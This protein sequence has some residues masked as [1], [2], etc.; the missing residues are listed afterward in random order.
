MVLKS[1]LHVMELSDLLQWIKMAR[2]TGTCEFRR[3]EAV[4][5]VYFRDGVIVACAA[6]EPFLLLGQFLLAYGRATERAIDEAMRVQ[7][8]TGENLGAILVQSGAITR[9]HLRRAI[10]AKAEETVFGLFDWPDATFEF[11]QDVAP[12]PDTMAIE[13][14]IQSALLDGARRMDEL[15]RIRET[16]KSQ[17]VV[18]SRTDSEPD[19]QMIAS[20]MGARL[21]DAIDGKR[22]LAEVLLHSRAS[23]EF[24][25]C[26][27]LLRLLEREVVAIT[28]VRE[29]SLS[30]QP[31]AVRADRIRQLVAHGE[32]AAALDLVDAGSLRVKPDD[33]L[34]LLIAKAEAGHIAQIYRSELP[35]HSYPVACGDVNTLRDQHLPA[36]QLFLLD[37]IDGSWDVRSIA[38]IAPMRKVDALRSLRSLLKNGHIRLSEAPAESAEVRRD[39]SLSVEATAVPAEGAIDDAIAGLDQAVCGAKAHPNAPDPARQDPSL[40]TRSDEPEADL[41]I[42]SGDLAIDETFLKRSRRSSS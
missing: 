33:H 22:T 12:G 24:L 20:P 28:G 15:K 29:T 9:E 25:A 32:Y 35:P 39:D 2:K 23:S 7:E 6:N 16:F 14:D 36:E 40:P 4:R 38:W 19:L 17:N 34:S 37:L 3:A 30:S 11:E 18:L 10:Q 41:A 27:F 1:N 8:Q 26:S 31:L 5:R 21:Y 13:I 42:G